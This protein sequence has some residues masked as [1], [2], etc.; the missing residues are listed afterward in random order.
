MALSEANPSCPTSSSP[1]LLTVRVGLAPA[2]PRGVAWA[3]SLHFS[4]PQFPSPLESPR[5][6]KG[7][8]IDLGGSVSSRG[9]FS[10]LEIPHASRGG[11][12]FF[13]QHC[14]GQ[15]LVS[16]LL[17]SAPPREG[18]RR[19]AV[20]W[21]HGVGLCMGDRWGLDQSVVLASLP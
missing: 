14:R 5:A 13:I 19:G 6:W 16:H 18:T 4:V 7:G 12:T 21:D 9:E 8:R 1:N 10:D 2:L 20:S 17:R 11:E 15:A 3:R